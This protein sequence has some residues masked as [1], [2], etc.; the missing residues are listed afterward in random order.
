MEKLS[1][2]S[3]TGAIYCRLRVNSYV[4]YYL[5]YFMLGDYNQQL[6]FLQT[7]SYHFLISQG[8]LNRG[9][10]SSFHVWKQ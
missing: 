9:L 4:T 3:I 1:L 10:I 8:K 7:L 2:G 5:F 6:V